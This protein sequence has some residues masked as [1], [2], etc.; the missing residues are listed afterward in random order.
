MRKTSEPLFTDA[1]VVSVYLRQDALADGL[2]VDLSAL[3]RE[4]GIRVPVAI[5][6]DA[7]H[8]VIALSQAAV[9]AG[10]DE[11]GRAWDVL[12]MLAARI[13]SADRRDSTV[14]FW[15]SAITRNQAPSLIELIATCGPG[16]DGE[17]V[18]TIMLPGES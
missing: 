16:D 7:H 3:A 2:L 13:R 11:T 1:D 18:I 9:S 10:C 12:T 14:R 17:P 4:Q 5:T 8:L 15:V 6:S